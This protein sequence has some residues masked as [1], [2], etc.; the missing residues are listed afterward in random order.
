M[1]AGEKAKS[2]IERVTQIDSSYRELS[3]WPDKVEFD[4]TR[5]KNAPHSTDIEPFYGKLQNENLLL[6]NAS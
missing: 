4:E 6:K 1:A 2:S 3:A 5:L